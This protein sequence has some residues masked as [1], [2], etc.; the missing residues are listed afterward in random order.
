MNPARP[1]QARAGTGGDAPL[2]R[3]ATTG[4]P[5]QETLG[6]PG[7]Q[8]SVWRPIDG[9][10][11]GEVNLMSHSQLVTVVKLLQKQMMEAQRQQAEMRRQIEELAAH[12]NRLS[13][14]HI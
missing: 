7:L 6:S 11:V 2:H 12:V 14:I 8:G 13:L 1:H 9:I 5:S 4:P 10:S 3:D